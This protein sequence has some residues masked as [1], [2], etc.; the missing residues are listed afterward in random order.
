MALRAVVTDLESVD[1]ALRPLYVEREGKY[2]V[3]IEAA[4]G[5]ELDNIAGLKSALAAERSKT[6]GLNGKLKT[7]EGFDVEEAKKAIERATLFGDLDP[8]KARKAIADVE[9]FT[10]FDPEKEADKIAETKLK[11]AKAQLQ[12]EFLSEKSALET[13]LNT[14]NEVL[15]RREAQIRKNVKEAAISVELSKLNPLDDARDA[16]EIIASNAVEIMEVN[17]EFVPVV[18]NPDKTPRV[19]LGANYDSIPFTIADLM[20]EMREKRSALFK[21]DQ[22]RGAGLTPP[23]DSGKPTENRDNPWIKGPGF[24]LT[25]QMYLLNTDPAQANKFKAEAGVA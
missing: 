14:T 4:D 1:E 6:L 13:R 2:V 25:K 3:D 8:E 22:T 20:A 11:N 5:F 12:A 15:S 21:P 16:L 23:V 7:F 9:K 10:G 19:K 24:S 17:G 18:V